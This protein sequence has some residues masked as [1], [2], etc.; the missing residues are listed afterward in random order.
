M[1]LGFDCFPG[2]ETLAVFDP[3]VDG[4]FAGVG[5]ARLNSFARFVDAAVRRRYDLVFGH[6]E[7]DVAMVFDQ[8]EPPTWRCDIYMLVFETVLSC[9]QSARRCV[10]GGGCLALLCCAS[11]GSR[12]SRGKPGIIEDIVVEWKSL[13]QLSKKNSKRFVKSNQEMIMYRHF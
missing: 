3:S 2:I 9:L 5:V 11:A 7:G 4:C 8:L 6:L 10:C 1:F 13:P 12:V